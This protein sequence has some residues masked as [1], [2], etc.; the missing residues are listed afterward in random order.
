MWSASMTGSGLCTA[1]THLDVS[2]GI[3]VYIIVSI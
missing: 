1:R 2:S 3:L